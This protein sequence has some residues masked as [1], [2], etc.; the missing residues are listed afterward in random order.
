MPG[1]YNEQRTLPEGVSLSRDLAQHIFMR[2]VKRGVVVVT[3][4]PMDLLATTKKQ[5]H[6]LTRQ[7]ER[8]RASTLKLARIAELTNQLE[9]MRRLT[10]TTK[11]S[12]DLADSNVVFASPNGLVRQPP[13]CSTLYIIEPIADEQFRLITSWLPVNS[14]VIQY[15]KRR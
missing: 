9:W 12:N 2:G 6:I 3:D 1:F 15:E 7:V 8:E 13:I 5:W 10:F 4:R 11:L 14:V